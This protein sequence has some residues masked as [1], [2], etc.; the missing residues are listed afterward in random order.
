M[1]VAADTS[2]LV[3]FLSGESGKDVDLIDNFLDAGTIM[4]PPVVITEILSD[5]KLPSNL[6]KFLEKIPLLTISQGYWKRAARLRSK[7][8]SKSLKCRLGDALI[9]QSCIDNQVPLITRDKDFRH[10]LKYGDLELL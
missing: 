3:A 8:I 7:I 1:I 4:L 2:S 6:V 9:S 10:F 5:P